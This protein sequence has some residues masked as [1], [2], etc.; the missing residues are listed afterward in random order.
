LLVKITLLHEVD[1]QAHEGDHKG[2]FQVD[3]HKHSL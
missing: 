3:M 2:R 1:D